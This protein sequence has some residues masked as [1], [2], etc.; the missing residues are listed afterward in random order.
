[1]YGLE[2]VETRY[3]NIAGSVLKTLDV[4][5]P[6]IYS[7]LFLTVTT[8]WQTYYS[9]AFFVALFCFVCAFFIPESPSFL[10]AQGKFHQTRLVIEQIAKVNGKKDFKLHDY[11]QEEVHL[12]V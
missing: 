10:I 5:T 12:I 11:F 9:S 2:F 6:I 7:I 1:M 4:L 3:Q 8:K